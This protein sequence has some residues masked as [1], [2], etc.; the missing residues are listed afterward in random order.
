LE[1]TMRRSILHALCA[2]AATAL[3]SA[4]SDA[5]GPGPSGDSQLSFNLATQ[6][7]AAGVS[8]GIALAAP[9]SYTDGAGNVLIYDRVQLVLREVELENEA[10]EDACEIATGDDDCAEVEVGPFLVDLPLGTPGAARAFTADVPA[11]TYDE[12]K[13]K[14]RE[15]DD[16]AADAAF[17]A[18]H[19]EFT[20]VSIRA[21][22]SY[23]GTSF[24][25]VSRLEAE[26]ELDLVPPL[27]VGETATTDL[28][29]M[30]DLAVWF[31]GP[32]GTLI[33]PGTANQGGAN[34]EVVAGNVIRSFEAFEDH[35]RDGSDDHGSDDS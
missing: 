2:A 18:A 5:G 26:L 23:N 32:D 17:I 16:D 7:L 20:D 21:E 25:F 15:P 22:G 27:V 8:A 1:N 3:A 34:Q 11:G 31:S 29:L 30:V 14:V 19:P 13:F 12:V 10:Q 28:T 9:E 24:V 6:P 33:D 35:D 4:C